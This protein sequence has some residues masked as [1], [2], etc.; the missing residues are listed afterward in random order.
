MSKRTEVDLLGTMEIGDDCYY[1]IQTQRG[2]NNFK[3]SHTTMG[4]YPQFQSAMVMVKKAAALANKDIGMLDDKKVQYI[5]KACDQILDN[6]DK[7]VGQ[8]KTDIFQG[9]AGTSINM[10][11]NEVIANLALELMGEKKGSYDIIN[12]CDDV[13][14]GQSTNDSYATG[15]KVAIHNSVDPLIVELKKLIHALQAKG[16]EY[17][18]VIKMGRTQLQDAVPMTL[19]QEFH[20]FANTLVSEIENLQYAQKLLRT[21]NLGGTAIGTGVN[22]GKGYKEAAVKYLS[23]VTKKEY[24]TA[25]DLLA[26]TYDCGDYV[27]LSGMLKTLAVKLSKICN[28]L[29]L[30][31]AGPRAGIREIELPEMQ[32]GSSIMPAKVNPVIPEVV[33]QV[34]FVVIGNDVAVTMAAEAGQLQLNVM[35]PAIA[36]ALFEDCEIMTNALSTLRSLCVEG[37]KANVQ[38][39]KDQVL[40]NIG[41]VTYLNPYI[42]HHEGDIIGKICAETGKNVREV[43]LERKL[44]T[45]KEIDE[46][47]SIEN[48]K[49]PQIKQHIL[50]KK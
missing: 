22:A 23:V 39:C 30:L 50:Q 38:R 28:D 27:I 26:S 13:N 24:K 18:D 1:G 15:L 40:S 36:K 12:P 42:G 37:I 34:C 11:A 45:E 31:S 43:A 14:A 29:R 10:N 25:P 5:T 4:H 49:N 32:P 47:L 8:F 3:I 46:I 9:G 44:F 48:L 2:I 19:G 17:K 6:P 20:A 33:N 21:V 41:I 7:W 35:E 16:E